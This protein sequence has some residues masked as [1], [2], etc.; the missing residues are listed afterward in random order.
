[1]EIYN[2]QIDNVQLRYYFAVV[3][4]LFKLYIVHC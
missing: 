2:V 1:M 3:L 4:L